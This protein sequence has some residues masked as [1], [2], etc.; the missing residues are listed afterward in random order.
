MNPQA[1]P[2]VSICLCTYMRPDCL[3]ECLEHLIAQKTT[4]RFEIIVVDNDSSL[5]AEPTFKAY[6]TKAA[7]KDIPMVFAVESEQNISLARNKGVS[8]CR[9]EYVAFLDDDGRPTEDWL[10]N[11]RQMMDIERVDGVFGP[12]I[13]MLPKTVSRSMKK[14]LESTLHRRSNRRVMTGMDCA[15]NNAFLVKSHL[16][17]RPG[18]FRKE[19]GR[20]GGEDV[21]LFSWLV[22]KG[23][24]FRWCEK[25]VV[26]EFQEDRKL[27][28]RYHIK[29]AYRGGWQD[30]MRNID[31]MG[32]LLGTAKCCAKAFLGLLKALL[33]SLSKLRDPTVALIYFLTL[34]SSQVGKIG[35]VF[36]ITVHLYKTRAPE[37]AH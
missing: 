20:T 31:A 19:F 15:T 23:C 2:D 32:P 25:A 26:Y 4:K 6:A 10:E 12:Q 24:E 3:A 36:G 34:V 17:K 16:K 35:F 14:Y 9:G 13:P 33:V 22:K 1:V 11:L 8:L 30:S 27:T 5:S 21:D 29:R 18:P 7:N 28:I 37:E